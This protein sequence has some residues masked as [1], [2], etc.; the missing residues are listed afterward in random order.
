MTRPN[1]SNQL[2]PPMAASEEP[3][4]VRLSEDPTLGARYAPYSQPNGP[5]FPPRACT[6]TQ[7]QVL[8]AV[9]ADIELGR[10]TSAWIDAR[11][12]E[13]G[14]TVRPTVE[15]IDLKPG[16]GGICERERD[17][18]RSYIMSSARVYLE[19]Q[20]YPASE[21]ASELDGL[22]M[23]LVN[24]GQGTEAWMDFTFHYIENVDPVVDEY[25]FGDS[26][27]DEVH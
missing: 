13:N 18:C 21:V 8:Q 10:R 22:L 3:D 5:G 9:R 2:L 20:H 24:L 17:F 11:M 16:E 25:L 14:R 27:A 6:I 4:I 7:A 15:P 12:R 19:R 23:Y 26:P 1:R